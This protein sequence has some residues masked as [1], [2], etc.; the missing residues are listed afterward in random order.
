MAADLE[1]QWPGYRVLRA[2]L[3][4]YRALVRDVKPVELPAL[5]KGI[6]IQAMPRAAFCTTR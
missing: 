1:P 2:A 3:A 4:R 5:T 6:Q